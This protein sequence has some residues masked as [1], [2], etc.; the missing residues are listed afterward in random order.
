MRVTRS[1]FYIVTMQLCWA[2][3]TDQT[4]RAQHLEINGAIV[5]AFAFNPT[6]CKGTRQ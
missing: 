3:H 6:R 1:G 5:Q 4:D 2:E